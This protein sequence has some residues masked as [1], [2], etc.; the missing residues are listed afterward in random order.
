M[1]NKN[2]R[3]MYVPEETPEIPEESSIMQQTTIPEVTT[4][5]E[6]EQTIDCP[7]TCEHVPGTV[8][9]CKMLNVR[10]HP[11]I[12]ASV[13]C[14]IPVGSEVKVCVVH[15]YEDWYEVCTASGVEGF[16]MK[17]FIDI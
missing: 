14:T 16:C 9:E 7:E 12:E 5:P 6:P 13:L 8:I 10:E 17:Q 15:D 11:S 2:Y 4:E 1:S 3:N